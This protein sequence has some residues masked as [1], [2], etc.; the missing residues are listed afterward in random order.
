MAGSDLV[1]SANGST[2]ASGWS[3]AK[4]A[5]DVAVAALNGGEP[6]PPWR[7][8]DLRRTTATGLQRLGVNLQTIEAVLGHV[9]GSR[10]G[11]VGTYQRH[12]FED[13][14]RAALTAW[15][16][17]VAA[18]VDGKPATVVPMARRPR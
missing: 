18:L 16:A 1:F 10:S 12:Q 15:G 5:L 2:P 13:E 7:I 6:L 4:A 11:V 9:S 17:Y 3:N 14:A 8:H